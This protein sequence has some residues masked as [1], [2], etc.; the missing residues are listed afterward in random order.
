MSIKIW[1]A[2]QRCNISASYPAALG[3]IPS[4]S[5]FSMLPKFIYS[6][7]K[8]QSLI[9]DWTHLVLVSGKLVLQKHLTTQ[10]PCDKIHLLTPKLIS[11]KQKVIKGFLKCTEFADCLLAWRAWKFSKWFSQILLRGS[12]FALKHLTCKH[13]Q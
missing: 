9:V 11:D 3:L 2:L 12:N 10:S 6:A 7:K 4:A 5:K 1:N 8:V 13:I